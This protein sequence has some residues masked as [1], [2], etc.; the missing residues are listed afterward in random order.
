MGGGK[1]APV[2]KLCSCKKKKKKKKR[3]KCTRAEIEMASLV[4]Q[5][6]SVNSTVPTPKPKQASVRSSA[7]GERSPSPAIGQYTACHGRL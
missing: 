4:T 5:A 7:A 6:E 2:S 1:S 3:R